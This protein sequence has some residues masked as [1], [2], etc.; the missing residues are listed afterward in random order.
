MHLRL[1]RDAPVGGFD[2]MVLDDA[3]AYEQARAML[4]QADADLLSKV[5]L[6]GGPRSLFETYGLE[7]QLDHALRP[8]VWLDSGGTIVIES[9]EALVSI[10]VNTGKSVKGVSPEQ[11]ALETNL[12]AAAEVARQVR[13]RDLGG[14]VVV[15]FIDLEL[16]EHR[17]RLLEAMKLALRSDP[18]RTQVVGLS[19]IG[20]LQFTR[21]RTRSS[22]GSALT[23]ACP[24]CEGLGRVKKV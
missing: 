2:R 11:T 1:L 9:T 10:D 3:Q 22:P 16:P 17:E 4:G 14:I 7:R 6:H 20:L 19:E 15:D 23:V 18:A 5:E 24:R 8:R 21:E 13:L 12:E